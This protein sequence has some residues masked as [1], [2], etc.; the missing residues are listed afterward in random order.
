MFSGRC[1]FSFILKVNLK[2]KMSSFITVRVT[3][4]GTIKKTIMGIDE[5]M[6]IEYVVD[7]YKK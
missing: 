3:C 6:D 2:I 4:C 1:S 7:K 5:C